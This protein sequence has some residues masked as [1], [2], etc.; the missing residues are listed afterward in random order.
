MK[1]FKK[2]YIEITNNCNLACSFCS[3]DHREKE[4]ITL[5]KMET[6]LKKINDYT[7]YV[8]LH[9]KGEPLLHPELEGILNLCEKYHK[10]VNIT[11][12]G[13]LLKEKCDLLNHPTIRQIN[14]S[15][16]SENKKENYLEDIFETVDKLNS[17]IIIYR[18]WTMDNGILNE[19]SIEIV[20][21][22]IN[23]YKLSPEIV[24]K[25]KTEKHIKIRDNLYMDKANEFVWP[26]LEN[27]YN[28]DNGFCYALR[29]QL[30]I[31][32]DGTVVPC[33][34]DSDRV[35]NLGNIYEQTL[36]EI[37]NSNHYQEIKQGFCNRQVTEELCK[38]CSFKNNLA[39][40][41]GV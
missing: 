7:D 21:K 23:Y 12:N 2:I 13:T 10:Q 32:V 28:N 15:L 26:N 24:E 35:I 17:K 27:K 31:L 5:E 37:V 39:K 3:I 25:I 36:E 19:K 40:N 14:L 38:H 8:Y 1:K 6:L 33:C 41:R 20:N 29:D 11:T 18:F 22:I 34:L 9:V 30:A 4:T 16:H